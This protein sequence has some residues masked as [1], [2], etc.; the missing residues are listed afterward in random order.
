[1]APAQPYLEALSNY[2]EEM[3]EDF[4]VGV[5]EPV[6]YTLRSSGK[7]IRPILTCYCGWRDEHAEAPD[8]ALVRAGA[9]VELVH[10]ATLVHDDILDEASLRHQ[11]AT[12]AEKYGK[13]AAVLLGDTIFAQALRLASSFPTVDVCRDISLATRRVCTGEVQQTL[14]APDA[15][16]SFDDYREIIQ[17]KTGELFRVSCRLGASLAGYSR[18]FQAAAEHF[19]MQLGI[20][21]QI[22]DDLADLLDSEE[23]IGKTLG[24][25][26]ASGK[27]TLPMLLLL[28]RL[29]R[30]EQVALRAELAEGT[31]NGLMRLR[32]QMAAH[33]IV[34]SV[35]QYF[36]HE[37]GQGEAALAPFDELPP[38]RYLGAISSFIREQIC[39]F[40]PES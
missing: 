9:V 4:E 12:V 38:A 5:R 6:R 29:D 31:P 35:M 24:T 25:D 14:R 37:L 1:M 21:Y 26:L 16:V 33:G 19:G 13:K 8:P 32:E 34:G 11:R 30:R 28:E 39:R 20:A 23:R 40:V 7:R 36:E 22:F 27:L 18:D 15:R 10:L 17:L 2:L 3:V